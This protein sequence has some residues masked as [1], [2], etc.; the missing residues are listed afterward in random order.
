MSTGPAPAS[1]RVWTVPNLLSALR[2]V[3]VPVFLWL[4]LGRHADGWAVIV[5]ML[6]G[7]SDYADGKIARRFNLTSR[8]G[9]LLDPAAD[10]LYILAT[11]AA[12]TARGIIPI[13]L[14][15]VLVGRDLVLSGGLVALRRAGHGPP[16]V[17]FLGK[18]AT[19][20]L[21]YAFPGLL[22]SVGDNTLGHVM[23]PLAWAFTGWGAALYLWSGWLYLVEERRVLAR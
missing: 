18:A 17:H 3:G 12:L 9:E 16:P 6:A 21:L 20:N 14:A 15:A 2:L 11:L 19:L 1:D 10:R 7:F 8:V 22:L 5:L 23:R 13:W 4:A